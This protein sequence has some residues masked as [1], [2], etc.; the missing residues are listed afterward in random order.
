MLADL[1]VELLKAMPGAEKEIDAML[2]E[3]RKP[4]VEEE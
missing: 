2:D 3:L 4:I 1:R